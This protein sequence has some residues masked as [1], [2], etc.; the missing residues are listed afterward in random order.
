MLKVVALKEC[1]PGVWAGEELSRSDRDH[2]DK[3]ASPPTGI[4]E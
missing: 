2:H 1:P 4:E 3:L